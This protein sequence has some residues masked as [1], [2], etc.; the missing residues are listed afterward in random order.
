MFK[1]CPH[2]QKETL[3]VHINECKCIFCGYTP[4]KC[5]NCLSELFDIEKQFCP[6]CQYGKDDEKQK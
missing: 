2:C 3:F 1:L 6:I 4:Y 5:P